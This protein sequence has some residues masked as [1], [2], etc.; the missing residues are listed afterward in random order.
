MRAV[1]SLI[2]PT[3]GRPEMCLQTMERWA[4]NCCVGREVEYLLGVDHMEGEMYQ[5]VIARACQLGVKVVVLSGP[6]LEW[7]PP[8]PLPEDA[9][10]GLTAITKVNALCKKATGSW[11]FYIADDFYP[12]TSDWYLRLSAILNRFP[13]GAVYDADGRFCHPCMDR[14]FY[15]LEGFFFHPHYIHVCSDVDLRWTAQG[16]GLF[17]ACQDTTIFHHD[18][19]DLVDGAPLDRVHV[20][21]NLLTIYDQGNKL[22]QQRHPHRYAEVHGLQAGGAG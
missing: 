17:E 2:H 1:I 14:A 13:V 10:L 22:L 3:R 8:D 21:A 15:V 11:L 20:I 9:H 6:R 5:A 4:E 12:E 7:P 18:H 16:R 19:P